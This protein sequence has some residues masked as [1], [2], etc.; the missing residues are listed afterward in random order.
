MS[1]VLKLRMRW[2][3]HLI[4]LG[5]QGRLCP[6]GDISSE[7]RGIEEKPVGEGH[8]SGRNSQCKGPEV[9]KCSELCCSTVVTAHSIYGYLN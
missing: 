6:G 3:R 4:K 1:K 9:A 2:K 5:D 8:I 7:T